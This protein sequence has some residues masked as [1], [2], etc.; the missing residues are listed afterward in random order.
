MKQRIKIDFYDKGYFQ[1]TEANETHFFSTNDV[2]T[3]V[4]KVIF[5]YDKSIK[6]NLL[7]LHTWN[8]YKILFANMPIVCGAIILYL[9]RRR[10]DFENLNF[11]SGFLDVYAVIFGGGNIR[12]QNHWERLFFGVALIAAFFLISLFLANF[13]MHSVLY[14]NPYKID[15][16][17]KLSQQT[18]KF[19]LSK[20]L[21]RH[22]TAVKDML[23]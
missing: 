11:W 13:S 9:I 18:V 22:A 7:P 3:R 4:F 14:E 8:G 15:T 12:I 16:F 2:D 10:I 21:Q 23:K 17:E 19:Y 1:I 5:E 20:H 6:H